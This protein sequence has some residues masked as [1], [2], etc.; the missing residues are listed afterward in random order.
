MACT[1]DSC[2]YLLLFCFVGLLSGSSWTIG[3]KPINIRR[4]LC[5]LC[6]DPIVWLLWLDRS[7]ESILYLHHQP[8]SAL[9]PSSSMS[10]FLLFSSPAAFLAFVCPVPLEF[11]GSRWGW[12]RTG[13]ERRGGDWVTERCR[14]CSWGQGL[15]ESKTARK[16]KKKRIQEELKEKAERRRKSHK[17][18]GVRVSH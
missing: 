15:A 16:D 5:F 7:P 12:D 1:H 13:G 6:R 17:G 9:C 14:D 4:F 8:P 3:S 11:R 18:G 2:D 10:T